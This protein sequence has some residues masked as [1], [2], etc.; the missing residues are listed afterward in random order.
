MAANL[1][2][3][4][5]A[6]AEASPAPRRSFWIWFAPLQAAIVFTILAVAAGGQILPTWFLTALVWLMA[7]PLLVSLE[8]G[9]IAMMIFEPLRGVLRRAQY[10]FVD[11]ADQDPIHVLTPIVTLFAVVQLMRSQRLAIFFATPM[12]KMV[13][14]LGVIYFVEVFNPLQGGL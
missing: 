2:M 1:E 13:S 9:L 4:Y 12:A 10:L 6:Y 3:M 7:M 5:L 14:L 11:Y 8:A